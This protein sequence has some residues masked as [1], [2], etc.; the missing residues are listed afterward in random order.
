LRRLQLHFRLAPPRLF[1]LALEGEQWCPGAHVCAPLDSELLQPPGEWRRNANVL[2]FD[3]PLEWSLGALPARR[4]KHRERESAKR[5]AAQY[6]I[7]QP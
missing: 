3:V 4:E 6:F 1:V 7:E 2:A 5:T